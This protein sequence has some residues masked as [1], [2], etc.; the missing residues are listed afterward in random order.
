[1][2]I[3][4]HNSL[5]IFVPIIIAIHIDPPAMSD[6]YASFLFLYNEECLHYRF[7]HKK[8]SMATHAPSILP[9]YI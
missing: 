9:M 2:N 1:M 7:V 3:I 4:S 6:Y 8:K 5:F